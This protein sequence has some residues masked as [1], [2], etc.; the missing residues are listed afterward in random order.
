M[1]T[2]SGKLWSA[3]TLVALIGAVVYALAS[4]NEKIGTYVLVFLAI[5]AFVLALLGVLTRDGDLDATAAAA[6]PA[7]DAAE[8]ARF[9]LPAAVW[10]IGA[11]FGV[12]LLLVGMSVGGLW[13]LAGVVVLLV[14]F[15]EW[16]VQGWAERATGDQAYNRALR[17]QVMYPFEVPLAG[18][19]VAAIAVIAFSRVLLAVSKE[20]SIILAGVVATVVLLVGWLLS[21]RPRVSSS[22]VAGV[23]AVGAVAVLGGGIVSAVVGERD[24]E[25]HEV[26]GGHDSEGEGHDG[27]GTEDGEDADDEGVDTGVPDDARDEGPDS[28]PPGRETSGGAEDEESNDSGT[29]DEEGQVEDDEAGG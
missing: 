10:P 20:G 8:H 26:E 13:F 11:A 19:I 29:L 28:D 15:V 21:S 9:A 24:F 12:G 5:A 4:D 16:M 17:N 27:E 25:H 2:T 7:P 6:A 23:L 22:V 14:V 1:I 3:V 18:T